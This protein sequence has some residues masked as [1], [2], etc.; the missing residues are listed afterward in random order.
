MHPL[1]FQFTVR[2]A[3]LITGAAHTTTALRAMTREAPE[4]DATEP[5][6]DPGIDATRR[7][8]TPPRSISGMRLPKLA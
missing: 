1:L 5:I 8:Q 7:Q 6:P 3:S 4:A 2:W